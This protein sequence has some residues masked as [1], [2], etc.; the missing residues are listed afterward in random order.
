MKTL[1]VLITGGAGFVGSSLA[2]YYKND[3]P[4]AEVIVFDNLK[5]RGSEINLSRF[6]SLD[7]KFV[8]GDIR[9]TSDLDDLPGNFDILI[10][11]SAEPSV[12]AGTN[13]S[14]LYL[15]STNLQGALNCFEFARKRVD[16]SIFLSTSRVY[17]IKP[18]KE[19]PLKEHDTR[20]VIDDSKIDKIP[21]LTSLGITEKFP[22]NLARSLYGT[23]K[24]TA[25]YFAQEYAETYNMKV[26][27]NRCGVMAGPG[28]F[29]KVDQGV[30]TLWMA[31]HIFCKPLKYYGFGGL[32]KQVRDL[33]HPKDL[34]ELIQK[35]VHCIESYK[36][37]TFNVGGGNEVS[38]SLSELTK[39]CQEITGNSVSIEG[40]KDT[41]PVDIPYYVTDYA[42]VKNLFNWT[43]KIHL[44][45]IFEEIFH[46]IKSNENILKSII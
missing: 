34:Y 15:L 28:Q 3:F 43:P 33:L 9:S 19:I 8:H 25:E 18:L 6:K 40:V 22:T 17:S 5:R 27:S 12:H 30:F 44:A 4:K 7:I 32:G 41:S 42:K 39:I 35:Q 36:G 38:V 29:G 46:W 31:Q 26:L 14:P 45:N 10:E 23:T 16:R 37:D 2:E 13:G 21:G 11:A 20:F 24:L 1:R